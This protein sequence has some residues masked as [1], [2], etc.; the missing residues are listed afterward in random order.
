MWSRMHLYT[1]LGNKEYTPWIVNWMPVHPSIS[2][3]PIH[4]IPLNL[5]L[6]FHEFRNKWHIIKTRQRGR[7]AS[8]PAN[9]RNRCKRNL[10][11]R[12]LDFFFSLSCKKHREWF[13]PSPSIGHAIFDKINNNRSEFLHFEFIGTTNVI[14]LSFSSTC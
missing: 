13:V 1:Y 14:I 10:V 4:A 3:L 6:F 8:I 9:R 7:A 5:W 2:I 12:F 11:V